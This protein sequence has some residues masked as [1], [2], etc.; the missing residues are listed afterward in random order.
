MNT[1]FMADEPRKTPAAVETQIS[2]R[3]AAIVFAYRSTDERSRTRSR[4]AIAI[5]DTCI[6]KSYLCC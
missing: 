4:H 2:S 1:A 3:Y 6:S 5:A